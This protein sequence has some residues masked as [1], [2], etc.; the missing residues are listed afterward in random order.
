MIRLFPRRIGVLGRLCLLAGMAL[1][2]GGVTP[3]HAELIWSPDRGWEYRGGLLGPLIGD[4]STPKSA[5]EAMNIAKKA[6]DEGHFWSALSGYQLVIDEYPASVFAPE[7]L[8]QKG[9]IYIQRHQFES[10][11][12][13]FS[14]II[15]RY[16]DYPN[17]NGV[18]YQEFNVADLM[19]EKRPYLWGWMPWFK[20]PAKAYD[21]YESVVSNAPATEYAPMALMK[22][23][24]L[25]V[26]ESSFLDHGESA[27]KA[28]DA[29]RRLINDYPQSMLASDAYLE[30]S[31]IYSGLVIGAAYDQGSTRQAIRYLQ[32]YL[33][34]Y[35][36]SRQAADA[37]K[38][39]DDLL[40]VYAR[41]QLLLGNFYYYYRNSNRAA[42][43]FY[44]QSITLAPKS[45]AATEARA[46]IDKISH[47]IPAPKTFY[48]MLFGRYNDHALSLAAEQGLIDRLATE[49]FQARST[50]DFLEV[51]GDEIVETI[52]GTGQEQ[53]YEGFEP[54]LT[55]AGAPMGAPLPPSQL[56]P[57]TP[58]STSQ[59][60][61]DR[62]L[63]R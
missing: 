55:P 38:K 4:S 43:I 9:V 54:F 8:F 23:A 20:D 40:D 32:D 62:P 27:A 35:R 52:S 18:I 42:L 60:P 24:L 49:A 1:M 48:D 58:P 17:F 33:F 53:E 12:D 61:P 22:I 41:S 16:P 5:L 31:S 6:Q 44:N 63:I 36:D 57:I 47:G 45:P 2:F 29:L 37:E 39:R 19:T 11:F 46:Q 30:L 3:A 59:P 28:I 56:I 25:A 14:R 50:E 21:Y 7:A 13:C 26:R 10:A 51:P 34:Y 15:K